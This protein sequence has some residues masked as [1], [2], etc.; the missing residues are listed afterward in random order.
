MAE[1]YFTTD[2]ALTKK[3]WDE[4][5]FRDSVKESYFEKFMGE[6]ASSL[7]HVKSQLEKSQGDKITFGIR[8]RL[9]GAGVTS[10][11][12]L[13]GNEESLTTYDTSVLLEEYAHAVRDRG[14][15]TRQRAMFSIDAES[16]AALKDWMSEKID[17][18]AFTAI[19]AS[20]TKIFYK[21]SGST[22]VGTTSAATAK[23]AMDATNSKITPAFISALKTW[24]MTGGNRAAV[25]L[26]P[27]R[28]EGR[29]YFVLLVHP[30]CMYD[31]KVDTTFSQ[32]LREAQE[33]GPQNPLFRGA[34]AIWD[35]VVIHEHENCT[36]AADGGGASVAWAKGVFMGAQALVWAWGQR[37]QTVSRD[38][39]YGRQHGF[40]TSII[41]GT[42]KPTFNSVDYG[43]LG[44]YLARTNISGV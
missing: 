27:V 36:I 10:S 8:M 26:R 35:G 29:E 2:N 11:G 43:S 31:L 3:A 42:A 12:T 1:T 20:P 41:S 22:L 30:D 37:P 18:L 7:V 9:T 33:R 4:K 24:A 32:A 17:S 13:E 40:A 23:A 6:S 21:T 38:F 34:T 14:P 25:P 15:L 39:D 16:K 44:V 5:L 28:V 19:L